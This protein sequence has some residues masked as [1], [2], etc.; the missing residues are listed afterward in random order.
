MSYDWY[1][2]LHTSE[3]QESDVREETSV[4]PGDVWRHRQKLTLHVHGPDAES[5]V[6]SRE[7]NRRGKHNSLGK[8]RDLAKTKAAGCIRPWATDDELAYVSPGQCEPF[9]RFGVNLQF[10]WELA[11][12]FFSRAEST[13]DALDNP[14]ARDRLTGLPCLPPS[15]AKGM[16]RHA[17]AG[18]AEKELV[19]TLFGTVRDDDSGRAG[20]LIP[21]AVFFDK[22]ATDM[23]SPHNREFGVVDHPVTFEVVPAGSRAEWGLALFERGPGSLSVR[24]ALCLVLE[25]VQTLL[26]DLGMSAKRTVGYG[27]ARSI[28]VDVRAGSGLGFPE[29]FITVGGKPFEEPEPP[30]PPSPPKLPAWHEALMENGALICERAESAERLI[31]YQS[32]KEGKTKPK[33]LKNIRKSWEKRGRAEAV[34]D[35]CRAA[36]DADAPEQREKAA[37]MAAAHDAWEQRRRAYE[38][39]RPR[40]VHFDTLD[41]AVI[42]VRDQ[43]EVC[44]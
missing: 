39:K 36:L 14:V 13:F 12:P 3:L 9:G 2:Y 18:N 30:R 5:P 31:D 27:L 10:K 20:C 26:E 8:R 4:S 22:V 15:G 35:A 33:Q 38:A 37:Q 40:R 6:R 44:R 25:S 24:E 7:A 32:R 34:W 16:L 19:E 17:A 42:C 21:G 29:E 28:A 43:M 1:A 11:S 23:F 41:Q